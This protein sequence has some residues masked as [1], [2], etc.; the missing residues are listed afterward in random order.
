MKM[1]TKLKYLPIAA[2][3]AVAVAL[4]GCGGGGG[5]E[6][7]TSMMDDMP[8]AETSSLADALTALAVAGTAYDMA[9]DKYDDDMSDA[10]GQAL[11]TAAKAFMVAATAARTAGTAAVI[12]GKQRKSKCKRWLTR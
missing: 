12:A 10:N 2:F 4:A 9:K 7:A 8:D 6:P 5:G 1:N 3:A 11:A